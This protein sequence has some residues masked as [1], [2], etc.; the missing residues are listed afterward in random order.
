MCVFLTKQKIWEHSPAVLGWKQLANLMTMLFFTGGGWLSVFSAVL[1]CYGVEAVP[2]VNVG[3]WGR[4]G[5][6]DKADTSAARQQVKKA[7]FFWTVFTHL[8]YVAC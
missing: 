6:V 5:R 4:G 8:L 2:G 3:D 7:A 1:Y